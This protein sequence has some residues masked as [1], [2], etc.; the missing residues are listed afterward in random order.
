MVYERL[1]EFCSH[2][3]TIGH[4]ISACEWLHPKE[5]TVER[6]KKPESEPFAKKQMVTKLVEEIITIENAKG[7]EETKEPQQHDAI[8]PDKHDTS[9]S[10]ALHNVTDEI[11]SSKLSLGMPIIQPVDDNST[12]YSAHILSNQEEDTAGSAIPETQPEV[13]I[14][15]DDE[16]EAE[17]QNE[18]MVIK[19]AWADLVEGDEPFTTYVS[20]N[21]R[22]KNTQLAKSAGQQY[23]TRSKGAQPVAEPGLYWSLGTIL[24]AIFFW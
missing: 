8:P 23:H 11:V 9:F 12:N 6:G 2:C 19:N 4:N 13:L 5:V 18:F 17:V 15:N 22:K 10:M 16:F 21:K 14:A 24:T 20:K 7:Q 3:T 1:P